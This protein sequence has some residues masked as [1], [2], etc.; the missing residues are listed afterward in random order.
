LVGDYGKTTLVH[1]DTLA[2]QRA[3]QTLGVLW[4]E[5]TISFSGD[6]KLLSIPSVEYKAQ[7]N[8][9]INHL[10]IFRV[11]DGTKLANNPDHG[12]ADFSRTGRK[13]AVAAAGAV[14]VH[15]DLQ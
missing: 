4:Y 2:Q 8:L 5:Q 3:L 11:D 13:L 1:P 6:G 9:Y 10:T 12:L 14:V 7:D 15:C